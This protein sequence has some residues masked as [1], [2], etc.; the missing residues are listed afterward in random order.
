MIDNFYLT[1]S[2][3]EKIVMLEKPASILE[4]SGY[5]RSYGQLFVD[6]MR[7]IRL[8]GYKTE[9]GDAL[10]EALAKIKKARYR[11]DRIYLQEEPGR[12]EFYHKI[13]PKKTLQDLNS[14][15]NYDFIFVSHL[16]DDI[17]SGEMR[18][19]IEVLQQ[20]VTKQLLI[21]IPEDAPSLPLQ[22]LAY[23]HLPGSFIGL[24]FTCNMLELIDQ[25]VRFYSIFKKEATEPLKIDQLPQAATA[26]EESKICAAYVI[27]HNKPTDTMKIVFQHMQ[28]LIESGHT[29]KLFMCTDEEGAGFPKWSPLPESAF[30]QFSVLQ[31]GR[32]ALKN[33]KDAD[34]IVTARIPRV[35]LTFAKVP[36]ILW[37]EGQEVALGYD[38]MMFSRSPR[39]L[40]IHD[41]Y[42]SNVFLMAFSKTMAEAIRGKFSRT[43]QWIPFAVDTTEF[44]PVKKE[45]EVPIILL[46][47]D[48]HLQKEEFIFIFQALTKIHEGG[49]K[50]KVHLVCPKTPV[51]QIQT[52][53]AL[54]YKVRPNQEALVEIYQNADIFIASS[55]TEGCT[56]QMIQ[57]M[58]C[59]AAVIALDTGIPQEFIEPGQ[60]CLLCEPYDT[61]SMSV[62]IYYLLTDPNATAFMSEASRKTARMFSS[63]KISEKLE[64]YFKQVI[65]TKEEKANG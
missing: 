15:S 31:V 64:L 2:M 51:E 26:S 5:G 18:A 11:V 49:A 6:C 23:S 59:G 53:F 12:Y 60:N 61:D 8:E 65:S 36:V 37:E 57:A 13:Y 28:L 10:M 32:T 41:I 20:K 30:S 35:S 56:R 58:A 25:N 39:H 34:L 17:S 42:R 1:A 50:F 52:K 55:F 46:D 21:M 7:R 16:F 38:R 43:P 44:R 40:V 19:I 9:D 48:L 45:N 54:E 3:V 62:A 27:P 22:Q 14:L 33:I 47:G 4:I 63:I 29:V 24:D